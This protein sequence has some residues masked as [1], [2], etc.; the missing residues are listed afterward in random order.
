MEDQLPI[1]D[2]WRLIEKLG[3]VK[4][5]WFDPYNQKTYKGD[6]PID[7]SKVKSLPIKGDDWFIVANAVFETVL[8]TLNITNHV[9][10]TNTKRPGNL[11]AYGTKSTLAYTHT[12]PTRGRQHK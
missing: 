7:P 8:E 2:R 9:C 3:V 5:R 1:P 11:H 6:R 4:E 12:P 10:F